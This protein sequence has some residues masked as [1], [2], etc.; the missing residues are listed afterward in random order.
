MRL[1]S[2]DP[3]L[4]DR[5]A[6]V[7]CWREALLAQKVLQ[8]RTKGY[9]NHP[10]LDRFRAQNDPLVSIGSFLVGLADEADA[11]GYSFNRSLIVESADDVPQIE[12]TQ[13][14]LFLEAAVLLEKVETRDEEWFHYL[15][16][17]RE[18]LRESALTA[19]IS[20]HPLFEVVPGEVEPWEKAIAPTR[21][22]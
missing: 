11:R 4:L 10:Q 19:E 13:G 14:Q 18:D 21:N 5:R 15:S 17:L 16:S 22:P 1:W 3:A 20:A 9:K 12:V 8:G 7:A 6:L 2:L